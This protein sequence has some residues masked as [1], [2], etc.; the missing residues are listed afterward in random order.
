MDAHKITHYPDPYEAF[1]IAQGYRYGNLIVL[2][3]QIAM[4]DDGKTVGEGDIAIGTADGGEDLFVDAELEVEIGSVA[5][6]LD[7]IDNSHIR[8]LITGTVN[9][10]HITQCVVFVLAVCQL[11]QLLTAFG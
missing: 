8:R 4:T 5:E 10:H 6:Q 1:G 2:S 7:V 11:T 3:G 9:L